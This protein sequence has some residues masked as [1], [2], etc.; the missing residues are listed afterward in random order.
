MVTHLHRKTCN[1]KK[2]NVELTFAKILLSFKYLLTRSVSD[3][4]RKKHNQFPHIYRNI[5]IYPLYKTILLANL[6]REI[7]NLNH[8][9]L[10]FFLC[11][12]H[13]TFIHIKY[14]G[15]EER[16]GNI[17]QMNL[18]NHITPRPST[19]ELKNT[20]PYTHLKFAVYDDALNFRERRRLYQ[21]Q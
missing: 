20:S 4:N 3:W 13:Y 8:K 19:W 1:V 10:N 12:Q 11:K 6:I 7:L 9:E 5:M 14:R 17:M 15:L 2:R 16:N 21:N 18:W